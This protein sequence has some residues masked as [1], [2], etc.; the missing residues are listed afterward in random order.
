MVRE[1]VIGVATEYTRRAM[2]SSASDL[3]Q[4]ISAFRREQATQYLGQ[5]SGRAPAEPARAWQFLCSPRARDSLA[6]LGGEGH[7]DPDEYAAMC[8]HVARAVAERA[9]APARRAELELAMRPVAVEGDERPVGKVIASWLSQTQ[10]AARARIER[11]LD[12][13][14][15]SH[16]EQLT[17]ALQDVAGAATELLSQLRPERG[18]DAG[19]ADG[20]VEQAERWLNAS[21]DLARE[22]WNLESKRSG[23]LRGVDV[24]WALGGRFGGRS[25]PGEGR[26]RLQGEDLAAWGLRPLLA[27]HVR[28]TGSHRSLWPSPHVIV[29][30]A[31]DRIYLAP[32]PLELGLC[33]EL[34]AADAVGRA[35]AHAHASPALSAPVRHASVASTGRAFGAL[36]ML[37]YAEPEFLVR[38]RGLS[39]REASEV[40]RTTVAFFLVESRLAAAAVL[41]RAKAYGSGG[42]ELRQALAERA[43]LGPVSPGFAGVLLV[44]LAPGAPL[45]AKSLS[46]GLVWGLRERYD[47]DWY[48]N[49]RAGACLEG[50]L[51]QAGAE[52]AEAMAQELAA[53]MEPGIAKLSELF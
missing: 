41:A 53:D 45:R 29:R 42:V 16:A 19:P 52:S 18:V 47:A 13:L 35:C 43:L 46:P 2:M 22:S 21:A 11:E 26:F 5:L 38:S 23:G 6:E 14:L 8:T 39:L 20:S 12:G 51:V 28:V 4:A 24:L 48:R 49:P 17:S 50:F 33:S 32:A 37:R 34:A 9:Y 1:V 40:A 30:H 31:P 3:R 27:A 44:R 7:V 25:F 15:G 10:P 36:C